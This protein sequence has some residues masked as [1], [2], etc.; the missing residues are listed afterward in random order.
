LAGSNTKSKK[1]SKGPVR[2]I[3][4]PSVLL[5]LK[6]G[7]IVDIRCYL[8]KG[9]HCV[10]R[11]VCRPS[12]CPRSHRPIQKIGTKKNSQTTRI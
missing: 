11:Y 10:L 4:S 3:S 12:L 9:S 6:Q 1:N 7:K 8:S 5:Y 2:Y